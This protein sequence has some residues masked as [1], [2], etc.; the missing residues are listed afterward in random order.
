MWVD[1]VFKEFGGRFYGKTSPVHLYWHHMD[2]VLTRFSGARGP[3]LAP[4]IRL[5]DKDAYS[6]EVVSSGFWAGDDTVRG[7]AFYTYAYPSPDGIDAEPLQPPAAAWV[8]SNGSPMALLMYD[9]LRQTADPRQALLDFLESTYQAGA[10]LAGWDVEA[11]T[12]PP[13]ADL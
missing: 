6:H 12:T 13:L 8:D 3:A 2:L 9:D 11:F 4:D 7:A 10:R 5:S 1:G